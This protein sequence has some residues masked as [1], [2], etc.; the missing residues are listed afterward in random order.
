MAR[1]ESQKVR[2]GCLTCK[3]RKIKCDERKPDCLRC[4]ASGRPCGGYAVPRNELRRHQLQPIQ[5]FPDSRMRAENRAIQ[6]FSEM[7][8]PNL[9]RPTEPYFWTHLSSF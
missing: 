4:A 6:F 9:S 2:T 7:V 1:K 5:I 8:G 3:F